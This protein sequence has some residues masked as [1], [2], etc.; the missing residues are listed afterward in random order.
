MPLAGTPDGGAGD[1]ERIRRYAAELVAPAPD[2]ILTSGGSVG[3]MRQATRTVPIAFRQTPD[4]I[5]A[6]PE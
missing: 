3:A 4:P 1:T 5:G 6:G 2:V